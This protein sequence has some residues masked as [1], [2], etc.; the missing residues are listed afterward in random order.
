MTTGHRLL[1]G[2]NLVV[3]GLSVG[4][5]Q[6]PIMWYWYETWLHPFVIDWSKYRLG[7]PS[8]LLHHVLAR[9]VGISTAFQTPVT[10]PLHSPNGRQMP[11]VRAVQGDCERVYT[12]HQLP[13][14]FTRHSCLFKSII[15]VD[16]KI[17]C[18]VRTRLFMF[19]REMYLYQNMFLFYF[20]ENSRA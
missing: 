16:R 5:E 3:I 15:A 13:K 14:N 18:A 1:L 8:A 17:L 11:A 6:H 9:P 12:G 7:L 20:R 4:Y 10:V 2:H 19:H